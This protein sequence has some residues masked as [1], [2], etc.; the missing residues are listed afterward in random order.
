MEETKLTIR[1]TMLSVLCI[2]L[3]AVAFV[4]SISC[5]QEGFY[6]LYASHRIMSKAA[7]T[8][9]S[10][11]NAVT[12]EEL[13]EIVACYGKIREGQSLLEFGPETFPTLYRHVGTDLEMADKLL[14]Y[15]EILLVLED[16]KGTDQEYIYIKN[17]ADEIGL[18]HPLQAGCQSALDWI[19]DAMASLMP[20]EILTSLQD[21]RKGEVLSAFGQTDLTTTD[22]QIASLLLSRDVSAVNAIINDIDHNN[23]PNSVIN[24]IDRRGTN[25]AIGI[26]LFVLALVLLGLGRYSLKLLWTAA[27]RG[28]RGAWNAAANTAAGKKLGAHTLTLSHKRHQRYMNRQKALA[29][30]HENQPKKFKYFLSKRKTQKVLVIVTFSFIPLLLLIVFTYL[31][32]IK[33]LQFSF[34]EMSY[35][36]ND[37]WVGLENYQR[38]FTKP[39]YVKS[40]F[41]SL[42]YMGGALIQLALALFFATLLSFRPRGSSF[43]K[44]SLFFP[45]MINGIAIGFMFKFFFASG[46]VLDTVLAQLGLYPEVLPM[47]LQDQ[48]INN[49]SMVFVSLWKYCGQ[50]MVLFIGAIMSVDPALYEAAAIDGAHKGHQF[51]YIMLP[52]IKTVFMLN[53]ILSVTGSLSAFEP[54]YVV[55]S[56]GANGTATFF[57]QIH[58]MA[59]ETGQ[60][61]RASAM[62]MVLL[63][64]IFIFTIGQRLMFRY[65]LKDSESAFSAKGNKAK[66]V[67]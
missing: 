9:R 46:N 66:A 17:L 58:K 19:P 51:R 3:S 12:S 31:P 44:G 25:S 23:V 65:V 22:R 47:W 28:C 13:D 49:F 29:A 42:Y 2:A 32:F 50:N 37:G 20:G 38:I 5:M 61:G 39:E 55:G 53:L 26:M 36:K 54:P 24:G 35:T 15:T 63:V 43:F 6:G 40:M 7:D 57:I 10:T 62:A 41:L 56:M 64:V 34:F 59:H 16:Y 45:S 18:N 21:E 14:A 52:S 1:K 48:S 67:W 30:M 8:S 60:L 11:N 4:F 27:A 33:M